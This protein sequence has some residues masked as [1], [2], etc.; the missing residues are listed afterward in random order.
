MIIS[1]DQL[2]SNIATELS[3]NSTGQISPYDIRHNLLD[4]IDSVHILMRGHDLDT[5][6]FASL[7]TRVTQ[8]GAN[9]FI[10]RNL[11]NAINE[12]NSA[13]GHSALRGNFQGVKNTAL[14]SNALS[15]NIY[16]GDNVAVG[17][18]SVTS[19]TTGYANVG[20]GNYTLSSNRLGHY[21]IAIGHA[22][23]YYIGRNTSN[24]LF[25]ASHPVDSGY[26]CANPSG[27]GLTPLVYG[28]LSL[29][30]FG[31]GVTSLHSDATLQVSGGIAPS[32]DAVFDLGSDS[33]QFNQL[34]L[35]NGI[36]LPSGNI[37]YSY[38][39]SG[40]SISEDL[41]PL[42]NNKYNL[43]TFENRWST[44][45]FDE[46]IANTYTLIESC[47]FKCKTLFLGSSGTC[48]PDVPCGYLND[49]E[50]I[51]AGLIIQSSGS[52]PYYLRNYYFKFSPQ[53]DNITCLESPNSVYAKSSWSSN[54]SIDVSGGCHVKTD[55]VLSSGHLSLATQPDCFGVFIKDDVY[56]EKIYF[57]RE[58]GVSNL[59]AGIGN[60]N[61]L[62]GSSG[63][64]TATGSY[65][66]TYGA[67]ES[68]VNIKQ[69]FLTGIEVNEI[70]SL[71][72]LSKLRG[73][74]ITYFDDSDLD[75][76][77]PLSD[78]FAISS[79]NNTSE[80]VYSFVMMKG[81]N[82]DGVIGI[83]DFGNVSHTL[84]PETTLNI[85]SQR[86][87]IIRSTSE[88]DGA[89]KSALQL[90][91]QDN[92]LNSGVEIAYYNNSGIADISMYKD[93]GQNVAVRITE[94]GKIGLF[95]V[96]GQMRDMLT[97]GG[98]GYPN[99][100]ISI[101]ES[102]N[103]VFSTE[104][105]GK[106]IVREKIF[107][108]TQSSTV[109]FLDSSGNTFDLITN[110][111][112]SSNGSLFTDANGNT[113]AGNDTNTNR[114]WLDDFGAF[115]NT[116]YGYSA[117]NYLASGDKNTVIG[118]LAAQTLVSGVSNIAIG[119][120]AMTMCQGHV[121]NNI[122]IGNESLGAGISTDDTFLLGNGTDPLLSGNLEANNRQ[123]FLPNGKLSLENS[124]N[125][126]SLVLQN[127]IIE[128]VDTGGDDY[129]QNQLTFQFTGN[130]TVNLLTL[131][132]SGTPLDIV[133][134]YE[135][136]DS[137]IPYA[138]L[139]GDLR[140]QNAIRF[141]DGSSLYSS[142]EIAFASGLAIENSL[143]LSSLLIEGIA[144]QN[145][146]VGNFYL[147]TSGTIRTINNG[148]IFVSNRDEFL[149]INYNDYVI[150]IKIGEEYRPLW[151]SSESTT[152]TCKC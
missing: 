132:N 141:N 114:M 7:S 21:N 91:G 44:G 31:I 90:L 115:N 68:G 94:D 139:N 88:S 67:Y 41:V 76:D 131:K 96:S 9:T 75:Y 127:N 108:D 1:K 133:P 74:D 102:E 12:D 138:E 64:S 45:Y 50:L 85:R 107:H 63:D 57:A 100:A 10:N 47:S 62:Y 151:V 109:Y 15:C 66:V 56:G 26:I 42:E 28:D 87:S 95:A 30:K 53:D 126:E 51:D 121:S 144:Q 79:Y 140:L 14:G 8:A 103:F 152:C 29:L 142:K 19:N 104:K 136:A 77:G 18:Q 84:L 17:Y 150:A 4:I 37:D 129:P 89:F 2:V 122:V 118:S 145:I 135:F 80:P 124:D 128:I 5:N 143:I 3:D 72:S 59:S 123:L 69:R 148:D 83:N 82:S 48:D 55:R 6:N 27:I 20:L 130:E 60:I 61:F 54:I 49:Q 36:S 43:G 32:Q 35:S 16:G 110:K 92:C 117:L 99:A 81:G 119:Y 46:V 112:D 70:D 71:T 120:K 22:A 98:S 40:I 24:K 34:Y 113:L 147:P 101:K 65:V 93:S 78:R 137:G 11:S 39:L 97:V 149:Q 58:S 116:A 105:Y 52:T 134:T 106:L 38:E 13:F 23:G 86:D 73:F 111:Y 25:I 125:T 146:S 33:Y